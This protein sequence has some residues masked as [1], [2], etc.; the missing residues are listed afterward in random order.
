MFNLK[1]TKPKKG[2]SKMKKSTKS[3]RSGAVLN[4]DMGKPVAFK[5]PKILSIPE[6]VRKEAN[7]AKKEYNDAIDIFESLRWEKSL[8]KKEAA[9]FKV[10]E[11]TCEKTL[12]K[13]IKKDK[14]NKKSSSQVVELNEDTPPSKE[15]LAYS[16][17]NDILEHWRDNHGLHICKRC[18]YY[19]APSDE[20]ASGK[21]RKIKK[22][23]RPTANACGQFTTSFFD[24]EWE[25]LDFSNCEPEVCSG[26]Q[27][28]LWQG[29]SDEEK[30]NF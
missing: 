28:V 9:R 25:G 18:R 15:D 16:Q 21:C 12:K 6:K 8:T 27:E 29:N 1:T 13:C 23:T 4:I 30:D 26:R 10:L 20:E 19:E 2:S 17:A 3:V 11:A 5:M 22:A 7:K 24:D 14:E